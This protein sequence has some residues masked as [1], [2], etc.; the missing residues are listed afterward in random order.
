MSYNRNDKR[1]CPCKRLPLVLSSFTG[2]EYGDL[3]SL[4]RHERDITRKR[5]SAGNTPLHLAAQHDH[6]RATAALLEAG[7]HVN[8]QSGGATPLHRASFSGAIGTMRVLLE[9]PDCD[10]FLPDTSFG[11]CR[12]ALHKAA[13]GG[14]YLA[15]Q[16]LLAVHV[17]RGTLPRALRARDANHQTPLEVGQSMVPQQ[18]KERQ[19]VARWDMVAGG[20]VA[21]WTLCVRILEQAVQDGTVLDVR[22]IEGGTIPLTLQSQQQE[23]GQQQFNGNR[24]DDCIDCETGQCVTKAWEMSFQRGLMQAMERQLV[25]TPAGISVT[26]DN[27]V[28][29]VP[30]DE[31]RPTTCASDNTTI[32]EDDDNIVNENT[33]IN[34]EEEE[35]ERSNLGRPCDVCVNRSLFLYPVSGKLVCRSCKKKSKFH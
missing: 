4:R 14:R 12:I 19:S 23:Q 35:E 1:T 33:T 11:D 17:Q 16:L 24:N 5:D 22:Q 34:E 27:V 18:V 21:D 20:N 15:V 2:A 28:F 10:L 25:T 8:S 29:T 7:C 6:V 32:H 9:Q 30:Q 3:H 31:M 26:R 13:A